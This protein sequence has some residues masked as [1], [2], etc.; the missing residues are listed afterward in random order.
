MTAEQQ[1]VNGTVEFLGPTAAR[2]LLRGL[3][4]TAFDIDLTERIGMP[5]L[6]FRSPQ[7]ELEGRD[8]YYYW[9]EQLLGA[10]VAPVKGAIDGFN[11]A[12]QGQFQRGVERMAPAALR[13]PLQSIRMAQ[14]GGV[15]SLDGDLIKEV[16]GGDILT[17]ALGFQPLSVSEQYDANSQL[18]NADR[19][20]SNRRERLLN[21]YF[22]A[23][24]MGDST[25]EPM[26]DI[27]AFNAKN[28]DYAITRQTF[29][30]SAKLRQR[31]SL[32]SENGIVMTRRMRSLQSRME[33]QEDEQ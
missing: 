5:N 18:K 25:T 4:G 26:A 14:E 33:T 6:W 11:L 19:R 10:G 31:N 20:L 15:T 3:P 22:L 32:L 9:M 8:A 21:R 27:A 17:K 7:Q 2:I 24:Q 28:P 1:F 13:N 30:R 16:N 12:M 29:T 23:V